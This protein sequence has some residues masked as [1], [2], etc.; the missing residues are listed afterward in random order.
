MG[1][2]LDNTEHQRLADLLHDDVLQ[3]FAACQ[4]RVQLCR[5]YMDT[6]R[7]DEAK[8]ELLQIEKALDGAVTGIRQVISALKTSSRRKD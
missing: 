7:A 8:Q 3:Y 5:R 1:A 6:G 2:T 4:M